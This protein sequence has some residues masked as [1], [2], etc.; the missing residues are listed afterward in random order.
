[1]FH[2]SHR[3]EDDPYFQAVRAACDS[4]SVL[5]ATKPVQLAELDEI[6]RSASIGL[7]WYSIEKLGFRGELMGMA[8]GKIGQYLKCGLPVVCSEIGTIKV[9]L[10][11]Y[12]CG[13]C[14]S[15]LS[16][17]PEAFTQIW[18]DYNSYSRNAVKCYRELGD[19]EGHCECVLRRI[20]AAISYDA[21]PVDV[22]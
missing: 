19:I 2:T 22:G 3:V 21:I 20:E 13:I 10:E 15:S 11:H 4:S 6:V 1:M 5:F 14:V 18:S 12:N 9:F 7:A 16:E 17:L 8:A